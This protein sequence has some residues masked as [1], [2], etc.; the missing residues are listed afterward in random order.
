MIA[1]ELLK[2]HE[3]VPVISRQ[4]GCNACCLAHDMLACTVY[5]AHGHDPALSKSLLMLHDVCINGDWHIMT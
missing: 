4:T 3:H 5:H 2:Q 1:K